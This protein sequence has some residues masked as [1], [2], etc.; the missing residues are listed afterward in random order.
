MKRVRS[1][2]GRT[3]LEEVKA[4]IEKRLFIGKL[5]EAATEDE[6][7]AIFGEFGE[8]TECKKVPGKTMGFVSYHSW[9]AAHYA[10]RAT[11]GQMSL[12]GHAPGQT[13][14]VSFAER[15]SSVGRGGGR[16]FAKGVDNSRVF[17]GGLPE[18]ITDEDLM[19]LFAP[20]GKVEAIQMLPAKTEKRCGFVTFSIWGEALD[21][22]EGVDAT[23]LPGRDTEVLTVVLAE[24][25]PGSG[26][27]PPGM[28]SFDT[29]A[30]KRRRLDGYSPAGGDPRAVEFERAKQAYLQAI[31][32]DASEEACSQLHWNIMSLRHWA[33]P[34]G[35]QANGHRAVASVPAKGSWPTSGSGTGDPRS[36][37]DA[38]RLF[39][40]GLPYECSDEE[41]QLLLEQI[42]LP[43]L[44]SETELLECRVLPGRGCGYIRFASWG[45]AEEA[46]KALND[47]T[48]NGWKQPLRIKWAESKSGGKGSKNDYAVASAAP[49]NYVSE[50]WNPLAPGQHQANAH[51][52][53]AGQLEEKRLFVGQ[54]QRGV[55]TQDVAP[56]FEQFGQ[57]EECKVLEDKGVAYI[58]FS[59][60]SNAANAV[61]KLEGASIPGVSRGAGLNVQFSKPR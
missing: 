54:L 7:R 35:R 30:A 32:G 38:A 46:F 53:A 48:V 23:T 40:G 11:D 52:A 45:A 26:A 37:L 47:R 49:R 8:L 31:E 20:Y 51:N 14:V 5:P 25:K 41:L 9:A 22:I 16:H 29:G 34:W 1:G 39:I 13:I 42:Q 60:P 12:Q 10:L 28:D 19:S 2:D 43:G 24:P 55:K 27:A 18:D 33:A 56:I 59:S 21:A 50:Q 17:V 4:A 57:I 61:Q 36:D 6:L 3:S 15:T 58:T 44:P